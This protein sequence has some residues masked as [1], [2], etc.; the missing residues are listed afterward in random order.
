MSLAAAAD[1]AASFLLFGMLI[2]HLI[3]AGAMFAVWRLLRAA[4]RSIQP[5]S[6]LATDRLETLRER[7]Q[8]VTNAAIAPQINALSTWAGVQAG[9]AALTAWEPAPKRR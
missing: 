5:A 8:Q 1:V 9:I 2:V 3:V 4:E 7:L 6:A